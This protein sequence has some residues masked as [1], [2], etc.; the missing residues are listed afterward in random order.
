MT[1]KDLLEYNPETGHFTWKAKRGRRAA[2]DRAGSLRPDGYRSICVHGKQY[3]EHRLA[4]YFML[5]CWPEYCDHKNRNR[6]DNR[7]CNLHSVDGSHNNLNQAPRTDGTSKVRGVHFN[8]S[9]RRWLAVI[10]W[11]G[12]KKQIGSFMTEEEAIRA[13]QDYEAQIGQKARPPAH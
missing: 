5:G 12:Y 1:R 7:W 11:R 6:Q 10:E 3:L 13:R 4:F 8:A 2:G 9:R